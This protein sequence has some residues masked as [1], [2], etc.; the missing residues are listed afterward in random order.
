MFDE[1]V[2]AGFPWRR[3]WRIVGAVVC[4]GVVCGSDSST[5]SAYSKQRLLEA[6]KL[7]HVDYCQGTG[8]YAD[9]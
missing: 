4:V 1:V 2:D 6:A 3:S 9:E 5:G 7:D 8:L